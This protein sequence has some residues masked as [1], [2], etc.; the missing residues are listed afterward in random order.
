MIDWRSDVCASDLTSWCRL[1]WIMRKGASVSQLLQLSCVPV[2]AAM[3][4]LGSWRVKA[5]PSWLAWVRSAAFMSVVLVGKIKAWNQRGWEGSTNGPPD[6]KSV[7]SG[8]SVVEPV[9]LGGRR[10]I[11]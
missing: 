10:T 2:G 4:R 11:K 5:A 6:R 8:K 7:G 9:D 3:R 1:F